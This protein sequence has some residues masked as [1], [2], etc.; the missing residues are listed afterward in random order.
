[1][2]LAAQLAAAA[3]A[4][5]ADKPGLRRGP[6][7]PGPVRPVG[8]NEVFATGDGCALCHSNAGSA[9]AMRTPTGEDVSPHA[10]WQGSVMA[11]SFRDPYWR[12]QVSKEIAADPARG[13]EVQASCLRCHAPMLH[14]SRALA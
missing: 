8:K 9:M 12:A 7:W 4:Q 5:D 2:V 6:G 3:I 10:L 14:H 13:E 11:N 1:M